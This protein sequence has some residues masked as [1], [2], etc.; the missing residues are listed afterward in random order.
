VKT[1][2]LS[3][4]GQKSRRRSR[5]R[6]GIRSD[7]QLEGAD[8]DP[9]TLFNVLPLENVETGELM[10]FSS[11]TAGGKIGIEELVRAFSKAVLTGKARGLPIVALQI[12]SFRSAY[13]K[14]V[15]RPDF[16]I[17]GWENPEPT[18]EPVAPEIIPPE[19]KKN[20]TKAVVDDDDAD[21]K[22]SSDL[23]DEI[24]F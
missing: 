11:S 8:D 17:V 1:R 24:P 6:V 23:D 14:D 9:W 5:Y 4:S 21:K 12:G 18:A 10:T 13:G 19:P 16:P 3:A 20:R 15:L 2:P 22:A 7:P